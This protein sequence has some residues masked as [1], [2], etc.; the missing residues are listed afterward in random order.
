MNH[1]E[2]PAAYPCAFC[3]YLSGARPFT[4]LHRE[5]LAAVLVTREQRG[6]SHLLVI[7]TRHAPT[8]LD[9]ND[10]ESDAV[11]RLVR[12]VA[13]AI[14]QVEKRPGISIWQNNGVDA[15]QAIPHFHIHVAGTID[16]GGTEW[17]S[18]HELSIEETEAIAERLRP[19]LQV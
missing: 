19:E 5:E 4:V 14:D 12:K 8:V 16:G 13:H 2:V 17:D 11:M 3:D 6:P 7:T 10:M 1:L 9:I 18:V 15:H